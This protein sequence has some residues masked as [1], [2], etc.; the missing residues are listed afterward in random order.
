MSPPIDRKDDRTPADQAFDDYLQ[1]DSDVSQ[2]YRHIDSDDVPPALDSAVLAQAQQALLKKA[3]RKPAWTRWSAPVALA[4]SVVLGI[5]VVLQIGVSEKVAVRAPQM[6]QAQGTAADATVAEA[7]EQV[8]EQPATNPSADVALSAPKLDEPRAAPP[9]PAAISDRMFK[10][11]EPALADERR[12]EASPQVQVPAE[13][14]FESSRA[15]PI[16]ASADAP[17]VPEM[18]E[19]VAAAANRAAEIVRKEEAGRDAQFAAN[20][21][22]SQAS[23][24]LAPAPT[25]VSQTTGTASSRPVV[26]PPQRAQA[27]RLA[28]PE[29]LEQIRGLRRDSKML[30]ADEQWRQFSET[31]PTYQVALDD[32][33]RPKP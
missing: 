12:R 20:S 10:R 32:L 17:V 27:P 22:F 6:E 7:I 14:D 3:P 19:S 23:G 13:S 15:T 8:T 25:A 31:Y 18:K 30:E 16:V 24:Q 21:G 29:W 11:S 2:H 4:A 26:N 1:R 28:P 33:A 9:P 5:A